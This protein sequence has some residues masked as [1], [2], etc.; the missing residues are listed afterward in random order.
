MKAYAQFIEKDGR[1]YRLNT[2]LQFGNSWNHIGNIVLANPG[3]SAILEKISD[4]IDSKIS[5]LYTQFKDRLYH[6]NDWMECN[7]DPTMLNIKKI[8]NGSYVDNENVIE[9]N[10]VIQLFNSFNIRDQ[11]LE[12]AIDSLP[13]DN[14]LL[15]SVGIEKYFNNKP[16]YFGFSKSVIC[17]DRLK[18]I[19][20]NI[21]EKSSNEVKSFY[22]ENFYDNSFYHP[23]YINRAY[24]QEHFDIYK[25][26]VLI[27]FKN[28]VKNLLTNESL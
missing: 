6:R 24:K 11:N 12:Q 28:I 18:T 10:G 13:L 15:Y 14:E 5:N 19:V 26:E 8:F 25:N 7:V 21:F 16:T 17:N 2:L 23:T 20:I 4:D 9:L 1:T 27:P 22:K 3:S